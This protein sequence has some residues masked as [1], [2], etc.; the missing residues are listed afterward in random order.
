[1][2]YFLPFIIIFFKGS[3]LCYE[4]N[5]VQN[6]MIWS[7]WRGQVYS[8]F[9]KACSFNMHSLGWNFVQRP[10]LIEP[11]IKAEHMSPDTRMGCA[12]DFYLILFHMTL[13][14]PSCCRCFHRK[15]RPFPSH[16]P[17]VLMGQ[18]YN[19][20]AEY[21]RASPNSGWALLPH[22]GPSLS[23][24]QDST[25]ALHCLSAPRERFVSHKG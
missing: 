5:Y 1:M 7:T 12:G 3:A 2:V 18:L 11:E 19:G 13:V 20:S 8:D 22:T 17:S 25:L 6:D 16:L 9:L 15:S 14:W 21:Q 4:G 23:C 24:S 10:Q